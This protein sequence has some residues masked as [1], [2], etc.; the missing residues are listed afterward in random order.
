MMTIVF[1][2]ISYHKWSEILPKIILSLLICLEN[3]LC[4][5]IA[6]ISYFL[7]LDHSLG[8]VTIVF[9][10]GI[11]STS[12]DM[13][14]RALVSQATDSGYRVVV[15]NHLGMISKEKITAPRVFNLGKAHKI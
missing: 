2:I 4:Y 13:Y 3:R 11:A 8:D 10:P 5:I 9:C 15:Q 12:K 14:V 7:Y 1:E 6:I